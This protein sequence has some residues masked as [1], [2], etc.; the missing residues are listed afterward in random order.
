MLIVVMLSVVML[1]IV[2]AFHLVDE[3]YFIFLTDSNPGTGAL[4]EANISERYEQK[5]KLSPHFNSTI[6]DPG[7]PPGVNFINFLSSRRLSGKI[8]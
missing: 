7:T 8:S 2:A 3:L 4:K 1:S 5:L 6:P